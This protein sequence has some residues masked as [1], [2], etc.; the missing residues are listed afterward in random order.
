MAYRWLEVKTDYA[1]GRLDK[2]L[3]NKH[4]AFLNLAYE[5]KPTAKGA[6]WGFDFT[7]Q[8]ISS[9]R[10]PMSHAMHMDDGMALTY[11]QSYFQ[12]NDPGF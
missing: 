7:G 11:S 9:K 6:K 10:I 2:P 12:L 8:W 5:T 1:S 3:L 4:R